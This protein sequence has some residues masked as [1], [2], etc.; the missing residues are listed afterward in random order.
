MKLAFCFLAQACG[1]A[2][3]ITRPDLGKKGQD[4]HPAI[5]RENRLTT[6]QV[7]PPHVERGAV[8]GPHANRP[9]RVSS[10]LCCGD[11]SA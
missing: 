11:F 10:G 7:R 5:Y 2:G 9:S 4:P 8:C 3:Y 6:T 1:M